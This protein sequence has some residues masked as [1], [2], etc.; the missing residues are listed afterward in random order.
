M[1]KNEKGGSWRNEPPFHLW[2]RKKLWRYNNASSLSTLKFMYN[3]YVVVCQAFLKKIGLQQ[4]FAVRSNSL[5]FTSGFKTADGVLKPLLGRRTY[6]AAR[7]GSTST[8][9][10]STAA[11]IAL[12]SIA[13]E[14]L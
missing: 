9:S 13:L 12:G 10:T 8:G 6:T 7:T 2:K 14:E 3:C 4:R 11:P 5:F 1:T